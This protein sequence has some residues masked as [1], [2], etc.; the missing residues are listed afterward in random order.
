L[1]AIRY[2]TAGGTLSS[3]ALAVFAMPELRRE[4]PRHKLHREGRGKKEERAHLDDQRGH[5]AALLHGRAARTAGS[6]ER[7]SRAGRGPDGGEDSES[8]SASA[9]GRGES[10]RGEGE[11]TG[12]RVRDRSVLEMAC[13]IAPREVR[14]SGLGK[15]YSSCL[16]PWRAGPAE[17][18]ATG[19]EPPLHGRAD[20]GAHAGARGRCAG[21]RASACRRRRRPPR[22][23]AAA[24]REALRAAGRAA[25]A[26]CARRLGWR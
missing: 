19:A 6:G 22:G 16:A 1:A 8:A 7:H 23:R 5:D 21:D 20:V 13:A 14:T 9:A 12:R 15:T 17:Q 24:R 2:R 11:E 10:W 18:A 25:W 4:Q 3:W 26:A